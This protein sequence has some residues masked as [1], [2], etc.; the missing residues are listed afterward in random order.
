M[1]QCEYCYEEYS[2]Y[3]NC[4]CEDHLDINISKYGHHKMVHSRIFRYSPGS[5]WYK[6]KNTP[7]TY[8][9][10]KKVWYKKNDK[11]IILVDVEVVLSEIPEYVLDDLL[12]SLNEL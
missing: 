11:R 1:E 2:D 10:N 5:T 3:P 4:D 8:D 9:K 6:L 12:F 7:F